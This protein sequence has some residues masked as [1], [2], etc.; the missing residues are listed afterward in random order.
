MKTFTMTAGNSSVSPARLALALLAALATVP[1][2]AADL[3]QRKSGLWEIKTQIAGMPGGM[4]DQ[5][6]QMC[7]DQTTDNL[8]KEPTPSGKKPD[9]PVMEVKP[10]GGKT[11]LHSVCRHDGVTATTDAVITGDLNKNY[12]SDMVT[13]FT[14]PQDG[15]K[16]MKMVQEARW[17]GPCKA[18]QKPGDVMMPNMGKFNMQEMMNNPQMREMMKQQAR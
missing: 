6:M 15:M 4:P 10:G 12:R 17:L 2:S 14:P 8:M 3:P 11:T 16:E 5:A 13:R 7:V 18:G 9:C 1:S